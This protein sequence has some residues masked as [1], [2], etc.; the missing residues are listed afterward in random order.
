M[1]Y[2]LVKGDIIQTKNKGLFYV[3][4]TNPTRVQ[5]MTGGPIHELKDEY[6]KIG[7]TVIEG[8]PEYTVQTKISN[9]IKECLS[10]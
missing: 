6:L 3:M 1:K 10:L 2:L 9:F 5:S 4:D 8:Q 7:H